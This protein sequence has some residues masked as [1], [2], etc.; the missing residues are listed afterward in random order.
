MRQKGSGNVDTMCTPA[1]HGVLRFVLLLQPRYDGEDMFQ[2]LQKNKVSSPRPEIGFIPK[3][4]SVAGCMDAGLPRDEA[5]TTMHTPSMGAPP[6]VRHPL[7]ARLSQINGES[8]MMRDMELDPSW[9]MPANQTNDPVSYERQR[10][11]TVE[12]RCTHNRRQL[13]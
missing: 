11:F 9:T 3:D 1:G 2:V 7:G 5:R 13:R 6:Q 10:V 4:Y 8:L 12:Q